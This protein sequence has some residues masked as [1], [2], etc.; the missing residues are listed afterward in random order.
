MCHPVIPVIMWVSKTLIF[1]WWAQLYI[2]LH[3]RLLGDFLKSPTV[4]ES[5]KLVWN[6]HTVQTL[7]GVYSFLTCNLGKM[8]TPESIGEREMPIKRTW[9]EQQHETYIFPCSEREVRMREQ[10]NFFTSQYLQGWEVLR[11]WKCAERVY[12]HKTGYYSK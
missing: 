11:E 5:A 6:S 3:Q 12:D 1:K 4:P 7:T 9:G 8:G 2:K 10:R